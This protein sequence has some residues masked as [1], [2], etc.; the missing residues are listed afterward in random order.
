MSAT[1]SKFATGARWRGRGTDDFIQ[2]VEKD[3]NSVFFL[4]AKGKAYGLDFVDA[5]GTSL[6]GLQQ[7][8][9]NIIVGVPTD[10]DAGTF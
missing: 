1:A 4:D 7:Q 3:G 5:A 6:S 10:I 2:C 8:V 9:N